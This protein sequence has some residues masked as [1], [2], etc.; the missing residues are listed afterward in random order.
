MKTTYI[1]VGIVIGVVLTIGTERAVV[2]SAKVPDYQLECDQSRMTLYDGARTVGTLSYAK[3]PQL[4][5]LLR[6][7]N[8]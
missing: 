3:N 8:E 2:S 1:L 6:V 4:D 5:S 7:D